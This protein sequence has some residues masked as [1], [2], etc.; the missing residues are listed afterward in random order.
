MINPH[1]HRTLRQLRLGG[2]ASSLE[3]RLQEARGNNLDHMEFLELLLQDEL[4][5]REQRMIERR[6]KAAD[7]RDCS[8]PGFL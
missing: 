2:L 6:T 7:F 4:N 8:Y 5:V 1:L 3:V